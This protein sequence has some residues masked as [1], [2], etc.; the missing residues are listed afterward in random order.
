MTQWQDIPE[1]TEGVCGDGVA[2]LRDGEMV[3]IVDV[4]ARLNESEARQW[5]D[6]STAPRD[7]TP[8]LIWED[9]GQFNAGYDDTRYS[10]GYWRPR[11]GWGNRNNYDVNPTHWMPLLPPP[12]L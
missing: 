7:G 5:Q 9:I 3:P 12:T 2:I 8:I 1:W 6:I 11:G 10:I 4:V